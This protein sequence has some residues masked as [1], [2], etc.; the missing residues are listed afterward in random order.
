MV[1]NVEKNW[2][3]ML[4]KRLKDILAATV[5]ALFLG[6]STSTLA[7]VN[8]SAE[9]SP[10]QISNRSF[11]FGRHLVGAPTIQTVTKLTNNSGVAVPL[12]L[13][14]T[15]DSDFTLA[16]TGDGL[17]GSV[18][19]A[20]SSCSIAVQ[21]LPSATGPSEK[22]GILTI[23]QDHHPASG[24]VA[25]KGQSAE[26]TPGTV[27]ATANP[28]V[29]LYTFTIPLPGSW[30]VNFGPTIAYGRST[31]EQSAD[32]AGEPASVYVAGML[33]NSTYHMRATLT[34]RDG[35]VTT[36][37]DHTFTTGSLPPG[38]PA[39][40]PVTL[41]ATGTPQPGVELLNPLIPFTT[42]LATDLQGNVI[43]TYP[44]PDNTPG[45]NLYP[46]K[47][48]P[49]GDFITMLAPTS[50]PIGQP[51]LDILREFDLSGNTVR[52][53]TMA[54]LNAALAARNFNIVLAN[55]SHD[56]TLLPNG[57]LLVI[58]NTM[59]PYT[60]LPGYPGTTDV[61]GDVV[62]DLD[63]NWNPV[64]LWNEFD[65][66]DVNRH[67]MQFPDWTH[68]NS[69][70][71]STDDGNF[72]V[73]IRHQNWI[74]KV[75]YRN[76]AG[77]GDILW[78]LGEGGD[79]TLQGGIDPTDWFYAQHDAIFLTKNTTGQFT[80][81]IM[82]NGDD[83]QFPVGVSCGAVDAPPCFYSTVQRMQVDETKMTASLQFHQVL[84]TYLYS[85][86]GGGTDN[87]ANGDVEYDLAG[88]GL[89]SQIFEVTDEASPQ[90]VWNLTTPGV[91]MYRGSRIPSLYPG[92]QW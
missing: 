67:P 82:D 90:M 28:Q 64:W 10:I 91:N 79:F 7:V 35:T 55:Y 9:A 36:D 26:L 23:N 83:R 86:W 78:K 38:I 81:G 73:S 46:V 88:V 84:P 44:F 75:D 69:V 56:L 27:T 54:D 66:L 80:L 1:P 20:G 71:Y 50:Y 43:W 65:H 76:G 85:G 45:T 32:H 15:G 68:T 77:T 42:A 89:D 72:I 6:T 57:H 13:F 33:P 18:L 8:H 4:R 49:D 5:T 70:A 58:A 30:T 17:C 29:A 41:G 48:L 52:Q 61:V 22:K 34:L 60:D 62:V 39:S 74:V 12:Q 21:F 25:L 16:S 92:V 2:E 37:A 51:G 19:D 53:L 14:I 87:L 59:V 11:A 3:K 47:L 24:E 31:P 40:F 63:Q